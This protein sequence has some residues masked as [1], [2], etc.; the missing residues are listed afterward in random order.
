MSRGGHVGK[1]L[2]KT[3]KWAREVEGAQNTEG[4]YERQTVVEFVVSGDYKN[5]MIQIQNTSTFIIAKQFAAL[6]PSPFKCQ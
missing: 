1:A 6:F 4:V 5:K 2:L 3:G